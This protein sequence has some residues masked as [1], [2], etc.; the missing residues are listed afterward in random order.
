LREPFPLVKPW[1]IL[2]MMSNMMRSGWLDLTTGSIVPNRIRG[3]IVDL[4]SPVRLAPI[5]DIAH[6]HRETR[7]KL[8]I[9][10]IWV[11]TSA[12]KPDGG[13]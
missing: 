3:I 2:L 9:V 10:G 7:Q 13:D 4:G 1:K 11:Y 5:P 8:P 6:K 12:Y